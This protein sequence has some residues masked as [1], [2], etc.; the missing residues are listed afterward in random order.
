MTTTLIAE[1]EPTI[2]VLAE[3]FVAALG[4]ST[5]TAHNGVEALALIESEASIDLLFTDINFGMEPDGFV[6]AKTARERRPELKVLYTSGQAMTDGMQALMVEG[7]V[8]LPKP[9]TPEDL[10]A[11]VTSLLPQPN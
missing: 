1:D 11:S 2:L 9:Y 8:F 4:H 3:G 10:M 5:L 7:A 6:L